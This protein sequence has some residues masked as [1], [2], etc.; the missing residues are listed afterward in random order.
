[1]RNPKIVN[2]LQKCREYVFNTPFSVVCYN[3]LRSGRD[4]GGN[5]SQTN[6]PH[7]AYTEFDDWMSQCDLPDRQLRHLYVFNS[8]LTDKVKIDLKLHKSPQD[9][10]HTASMAGY[11]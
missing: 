5:S 8:M 1:M 2:T 7:V 9:G 11:K 10:I 4:S 3:R 6:I